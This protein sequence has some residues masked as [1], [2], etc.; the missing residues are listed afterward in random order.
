[1]I[2]MT[3]RV[4]GLKEVKEVLRTL[5][6]ATARNVMRRVLR[7]R[8][9]PVAAAAQ[10][11]APR[12]KG[13]LAGRIQV[14]SKL[15]PRQKKIHVKRNPDDVEIFVGAPPWAHAHILE[16]GNEEISPRP[17]MRPA[18]DATK[19]QVLAGVR[20]DMWAE[21]EKAVKRIARK[22][23]RQAAKGA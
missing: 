16:Y 6:D 2:E 21:I 8:G 13:K 18:W 17:Y 5:P 10:M 7:K 14:T 22:L 1:M 12:L 3:V 9:E 15:S 19:L 20:S 11:L 4:E 23:A